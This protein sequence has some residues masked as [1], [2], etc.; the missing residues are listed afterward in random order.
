MLTSNSYVFYIIPG[1]SASLLESDQ[2]IL[3]YVACKLAIALSLMTLFQKPGWRISP[4]EEHVFLNAEREQK[5]WQKYVKPLK[6]SLQ[7][8]H[9]KFPLILYWSKRIVWP[10]SKSVG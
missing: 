6:T 8:W 3:P 5:S 1:G 10:S 2:H 7:G 9:L 4:Y